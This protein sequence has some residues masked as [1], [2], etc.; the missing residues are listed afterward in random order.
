MFWNGKTKHT[1]WKGLPDCSFIDN[2]DSKILKSTSASALKKSSSQNELNCNYQI[3][4]ACQL[5]SMC[6]F[7]VLEVT[8]MQLIYQ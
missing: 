7:T 4:M 5:S 1:N 3:I 6:S 2:S 8:K